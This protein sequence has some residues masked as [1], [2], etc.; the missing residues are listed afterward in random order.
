MLL[1]QP[2]EDYA[3]QNTGNQEHANFNGTAFP[4]TD[5]PSIGSGRKRKRVAP[6][7]ELF[8]REQLRK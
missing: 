6:P 5:S 1:P 4:G 8:I 3:Y 7:R 2:K